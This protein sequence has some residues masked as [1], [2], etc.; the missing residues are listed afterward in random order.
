VTPEE[1]AKAVVEHFA[2]S[3]PPAVRPQLEKVIASAIHR[4][5]KQELAKL[6]QWASAKE[7]RAH[8]KGKQAKGYD[9]SAIHWHGYWK[10]T[11][12]TM[13]NGSAE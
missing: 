11:F 9:P 3:L 1:R 10:E 8:G 12:R 6:E 4:A 2:Q 13:R 5:V 7:E